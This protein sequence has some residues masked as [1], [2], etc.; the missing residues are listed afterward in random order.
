MDSNEV[1]KYYAVS[2][3]AVED[4]HAFRKERGYTPWTDEQAEDWLEDN[5]RSMREMAMESGRDYFWYVME[6]GDKETE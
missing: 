6:E 5:E 2:R 4:V 1:K 3:W